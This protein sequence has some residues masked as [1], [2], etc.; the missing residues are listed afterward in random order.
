MSVRVLDAANAQARGMIFST[1]SGNVT[2]SIM[3]QQDLLH[4]SIKADRV[5]II[6]VAIF[7]SSLLLRASHSPREWSRLAVTAT[8]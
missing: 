7:P 4:T 2:F 5:E 8:S 1:R 3:K 6:I